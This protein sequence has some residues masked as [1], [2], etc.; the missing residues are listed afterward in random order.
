MMAINW[1]PSPRE[2][3]MWAL[4]LVP[5][6]GLIGSLFYF[7]EWGVFRSGQSVAFVL[8]AFALVAF[9]T[10]MTGTKAGWPAY[11]I[12]MG[13][14]YA[15]TWTISHVALALVYGLVV[16]P[17][18]LLA[19]LLGRDRLQL[20]GRARASYWHS[21]NDVTRHDPDRTF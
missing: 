13:L 15:I 16:T 11:W 12:W 20:H 7:L 10:A 21:L 3:R 5:A 19:R 14:V 1:H 9:L 2:L 18:G 17:L 8:W 4:V 6:L